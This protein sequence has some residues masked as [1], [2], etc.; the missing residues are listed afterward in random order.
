MKAGCQFTVAAINDL[1]E[2]QSLSREWTDLCDRCPGSTPFQRPEWLLSWVEAFKPQ[3]IYTI[4]VRRGEVLVG[5][6]PMF[7]YSS[8]SESILAPLGA[9]ISDYL[10]W[11]I[12]PAD[13]DEVIR[14][15][16]AFLENSDL[17]WTRLDVTDIPANAALRGLSDHNIDACPDNACP[18]LQL[19][20]S[21]AELEQRL[22]AKFRHNLHT[23]QRR[24]E[25]AGRV[26][27]E[28]ANEFTLDGFFSAM[29]ELHGAR[30]NQLGMAGVLADSAVQHFHRMAAA[31]LLRSGVLRLFGLR[32]NGKLIATLYAL[33]EREVVYCY[34]Q[35]FDPDYRFYSPG[36]QILAHVIDRAIQEGKRV[37]DFLR[38][39]EGYKYLW[40]ATD[41]QT[42]R[43]SVH[44]RSL[45]P[46]ARIAA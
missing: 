14:L 6:A 26:S 21:F 23:A 9:G 35:A 15:I 33:C 37:V 36:V 16:V 11:L 12:D 19:P 8:G 3:Q 45:M 22:P 13:S 44:R 29:L 38:G 42:Y 43:L 32:L 7:L 20:G 25:K 2:L 41:R 31:R 30:W 28:I 27:V 17:G 18:V 1:N 24:I 5:L 34:L 39:R 10:D 4:Q 40:G 46:A